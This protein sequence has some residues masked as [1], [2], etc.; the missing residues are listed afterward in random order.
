MKNI[1][2]TVI[3]IF[4]SINIQAQYFKYNIQN[5]GRFNEGYV[6]KSNY[7]TIKGY[8]YVD[9]PHYMEYSIDFKKGSSD[10]SSIFRPNDLIC[11]VT[12]DA[13]GNK[14]LWVSTKYSTLEHPPEESYAGAMD[15]AFINT[16][17]PG[18]ISIYTYYNYK[19]GGEPARTTTQYMQLPDKTM[20]DISGLLFG[21]SKKM[22]DFIADYE[23]L[24]KKVS[25]KQKGYKL[26]SINDIAREYNSWYISNNSDYNFI[27]VE[28]PKKSKL[29]VSDEI[30]FNSDPITFPEYP[31]IQFWLSEPYQRFNKWDTQKTGDSWLSVALKM[32]NNS[33][34]PIAKITPKRTAYDKDGNILKQ[35]T[36]GFSTFAFDP[37]PGNTFPDGYQGIMDSFFSTDISD[38]DKFKEVKFAIT[39]FGF[40]SAAA[41]DKPVFKSDWIEFD[42]FK[43]FKFRLSEPF[44][45]VDD[46]SGNNR[47]GVALEI[48]NESGKEVNNF[49]F[50][51]KVYDDQ[52]L[53]FDEERQNHQQMYVPS[54]MKMNPKFPADYQGINKKFY[55]NEE[56]F[57]DKFNKIEIILN[58]VEY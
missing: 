57:I 33:G 42:N 3:G 52:G 17:V 48:K 28:I 45:F 58:R 51:I 2:F 21:F 6:V 47:F 26:G 53:L 40:A 18:P 12:K 39:E 49:Y 20:K 24:A 46:M 36:G 25:K 16:V 56:S 13:I 27:T 5:A 22:P 32:K 31:G 4:L 9:E 44:V 29:K 34:K 11:Y 41:I 8:I 38:V 19:E 37:N 43:G 14:I 35:S 23:E 50:Q 1:L 54:I 7:D 15:H 55:T 30:V 10:Q